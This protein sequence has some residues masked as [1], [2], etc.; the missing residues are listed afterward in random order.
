MLHAAEKAMRMLA[1]A[2]LSASLCSKRPVHDVEAHVSVCRVTKS[3]RHRGK[4]LKA[5]GAPQ[6]DSRCIGFDDRI[7]LHRPVTIRARL[8]QDTAAQGP[9]YALAAARRMNNKPGVGHVRPWAPV[10]GMS[11][12]APDDAS[13][14]VRGDDGAARWLSHPPSAYPCFG[15]GGVPRQGLAGGA[16]F[17]QDQPDSGPVLRLRL[18]Y[19]HGTSI[20]QPILACRR[21]DVDPVKTVHGG[22]TVAGSSPRRG[23]GQDEC[24]VG[25]R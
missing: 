11:V 18:A 9:A 20:A 19:H 4:D 22:R 21:S 13:V 15:S 10:N 25:R 2:E 12:R 24:G 7:E 16:L 5:E 1:H 23:G 8:V 17:F 3:L 14:V 6:L